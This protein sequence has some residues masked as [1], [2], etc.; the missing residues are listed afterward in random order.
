MNYI[1]KLEQENTELR[2]ALKAFDKS[3]AAFM[4]FL[5]SA[6]FQ[7]LEGK[8]RKDWISTGDVL[9]RLREMRSEAFAKVNP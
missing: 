4:S 1:K 3:S 9:T 7:G 2:D 6:K 8:E 5:M